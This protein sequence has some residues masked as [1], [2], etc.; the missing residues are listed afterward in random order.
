[1]PGINFRMGGKARHCAQTDAGAAPGGIA[2][3]QTAFDIRHAWSFIER[4]YFNSSNRRSGLYDA[5]GSEAPKKNLAPSSVPP[6]IIG[7][8][9]DNDSD[10]PNFDRVKTK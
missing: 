6:Q 4:Q 5:S 1:R 2:I 10:L 9:C 3:A 7:Q 8:F